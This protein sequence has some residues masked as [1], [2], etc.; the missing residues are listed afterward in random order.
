MKMRRKREGLYLGTVI[1]GITDSLVST[2]GLLA[3]IS[4]A[5]ASRSLI[6]T[7]GVI[8]AIVEAFS[9][10]VGDYLSEETEEEFEARRNVPAAAALGVAVVMFFTFVIAAFIPI[11]PYIFLTGVSALH[12]SIALSIAALFVAGAIGA[13][14]ARMPVLWRGMRMML[15]GGAAIVIGLVVGSLFPEP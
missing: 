10:A 11:T 15:L 9:M 3:G 5:G 6:I 12:V 7:T 14:V 13:R 4:V 2:V 1:F 8:Y